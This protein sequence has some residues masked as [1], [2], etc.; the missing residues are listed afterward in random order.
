MSET[1]LTYLI[2]ALVVLPSMAL[3]LRSV[4]R[5]EARALDAAEKGKLY[6]EGPK[7]QHPKIDTTDC[8][9]C[10]ICTS[11]CPEGDVLAM[12]GGKAVIINGYKCIGHGLCADVCPVGAIQLVM[13]KPSMMPACPTSRRARDKR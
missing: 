5:R 3:Y 2:A 4:K 10:G 6:S 9:G 12:L 7:A 1:F 8:I 13:A 11:V